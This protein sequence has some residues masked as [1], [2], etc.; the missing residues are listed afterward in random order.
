MIDSDLGH[1]FQGLWMVG[2][3]KEPH[4]TTR[5]DCVS[6]MG[7]WGLFF[8]PLTIQTFHISFNRMY[9]FF[10]IKM[11]MMEVIAFFF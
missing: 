1:M 8:F 10:I 5:N 11:Q 4:W 9:F 2:D 7:K 3:W 6:P